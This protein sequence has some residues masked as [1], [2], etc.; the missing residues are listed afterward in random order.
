MAGKNAIS[1]SQFAEHFRLAWSGVRGI[2][3]HGHP[4]RI[5]DAAQLPRRVG[6]A[7]SGGADSMA[8]A[9]LCRQLEKTPI[10]GPISVTAFIV[11]HRARKESSEEASIVK[12]RLSKLGIN[13]QIL[14]L[15]WSSISNSED[16]SV[17]KSATPSMPTA[18]ETHARRL[19]FQALGRAC[20][21]NGIQALLLGH[22][23][24]DSIETTL[25]RLATGARR[26]G[27]G[28]IQ[29]IA[30]IPECHG[31]FGVSESG[32]SMSLSTCTDA[33][34]R[35][36]NVSAT[37]MKE[38]FATGGVFVCRPLLSCSKARLLATCHENDVPYVS[39]PTN[40][41][42]TLTPRNAVR[43]LI[44]ANLLPRA[45]Q[46]PRILALIRSSRDL[47][48][49]ASNFS[50]QLLA[51]RCRILDISLATGIMTIQFKSIPTWMDSL[52][53][54]DSPKWTRQI[55]AMTLRRITE[56]ISPFPKNQ[57]SLRS[58]EPFISRVF[59]PIEGSARCENTIRRSFT[60][61]GVMFTP[62]DES[63]SST[64]KSH[65][66]PSGEGSTWRL[67][68]QPFMKDRSPVLSV[69]APLPTQKINS[70]FQPTSTGWVLWDDRYWFNFSIAPSKNLT[71]DRSVSSR[72][73]TQTER[74][75]FQ[76][77]PFQQNDFQIMASGGQ[78]DHALRRSILRKLLSSEAPGPTRYTIPVLL[79]ET[80]NEAEESE[81]KLLSLP[82]LDFPMSG[83][84]FQYSQIM[85]IAAGGK[86]WTLKWS[87]MF[88]MLDTS[89]LRLMGKPVEADS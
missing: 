76:I 71:R 15:D 83:R 17:S 30:R 43:S 69:E 34:E 53:A 86:R 33:P 87:W 27:L 41:D 8:L 37:S 85:D 22:H 62:V 2:T 7:I 51:S 67:S 56:L 26:A 6:L 13:T 77:R 72:V 20:R 81:V 63:K 28:G 32:S 11:D 38:K 25:W 65:G 9:Y 18:F 68:R 57:F 31:I 19:R 59:G 24:D 66:M 89:A 50:D 29:S 35:G 70:K 74:V 3:P 36:Q 61:G 46:G 45:L 42:P 84:G 78:K 79:H 49:V 60:L 14:K 55:Q 40:F 80:F 16:T 12:S 1:V 73:S 47:L 10:G 64:N 48:Q 75:S 58:F 4:G 88:K 82:T 44:T 21:E 54:H 52:Q 39:D 5:E 23:R